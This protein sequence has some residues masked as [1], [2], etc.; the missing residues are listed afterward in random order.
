M[1]RKDR[2][3]IPGRENQPP[4]KIVSAREAGPG[5]AAE[6][7]AGQRLEEGLT[8]ECDPRDALLPGRQSS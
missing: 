8:G 6:H 1:G 7:P 3:A 4:R 5:G 2:G